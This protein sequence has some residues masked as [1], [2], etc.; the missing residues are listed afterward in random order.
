MPETPPNSLVAI[1]GPTGS[2]KSGLAMALAAEFSGEVVSCD[3]LQ[4]YRGFD[5]G[6]AKLAPGERRGIPHHLMDILDPDEIFTAGEFARRARAA[7]DDISS[8]AKLPVICGGTGFYLRALLDGLFAGPQRDGALRARLEARRRR[9]PESL[10]RILRRLDPAAARSIHWNDTPKL[11]RAIEVCLL[12]R[13]PLTELYGTGRNA[14]SGYSP[15]Q[16]GLAPPRQ[17]LYQRL[18][19]RCRLMFAGGL[20][21]E[22]RGILAL[23]YPSSAKPFES[24]GYKQVVRMLNGELSGEEALLLAQRSTRRYAKRQVTW[25]RADA[26]IEWLTGFGDE[27]DVRRRAIERVREFLP[28]AARYIE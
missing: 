23:G 6:T 2:G 11:I 17:A 8:R 13:R 21:E 22:V 24:V 5:I 7:L 18:D 26:R 15:L 28:S 9:R 14:L 4:I 25:F 12:T 1:V 10:H 3:S 20:V 16:L 19:E 27:E